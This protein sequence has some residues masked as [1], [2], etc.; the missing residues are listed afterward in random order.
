LHLNLEESVE[1]KRNRRL[2]QYRRYSPKSKL[3]PP[4]RI[5][6]RSKISLQLLLTSYLPKK[7][8]YKLKIRKL[9]VLLL[10]S[11]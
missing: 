6:P 9:S 2:L 5:L 4:K 8:I 7:T 1:P 3:L 10:L 11:L